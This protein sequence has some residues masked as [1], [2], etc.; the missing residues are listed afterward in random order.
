[1]ALQSTHL[2]HFPD[3]EVCD[4]SHV[5]VSECRVDG[6]RPRRVVHADLR[7]Q[8]RVHWRNLELR[9]SWKL[10]KPFQSAALLRALL[11]GALYSAKW[12]MVGGCSSGRGLIYRSPVIC[13]D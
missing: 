9:D 10:A 5:Q 11:A 7:V 4:A 3:S 12:R 8:Q 2:R 6:H 1:M 13:R